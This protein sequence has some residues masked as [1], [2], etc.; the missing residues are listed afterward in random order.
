MAPDRTAQSALD[1][2]RNERTIRA[3]YR[4]TPIEEQSRHV[5]ARVDLRR[6]SG[7]HWE[8][9]LGWVLAVEQRGLDG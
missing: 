7:E 8:R 5:D 6:A 2:K 9:K 4:T 1:F 3:N